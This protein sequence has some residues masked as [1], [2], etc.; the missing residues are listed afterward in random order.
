MTWR[1][2]VFWDVAMSAGTPATQYGQ[3]GVGGL[4]PFITSAKLISTLYKIHQYFIILLSVYRVPAGLCLVCTCSLLGYS[5]D[6][7]RECVE[8]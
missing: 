5:S 3:L 7:C 8:L 2:S 1:E 4:H 6:L